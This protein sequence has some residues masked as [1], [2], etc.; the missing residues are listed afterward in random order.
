VL[1]H[2]ETLTVE[3]LP[4]G[5]WAFFAIAEQATGL[6]SLS[7]GTAH[8]L[9]LDARLRHP[10]RSLTLRAR[11]VQGDPLPEKIVSL[12]LHLREASDQD[13]ERLLARVR[14]VTHLS[15]RG[16]PVSDELIEAI[17]PRWRLEYLDVVDTR[18][19]DECVRRIRARYPKLRTHPNPDIG[20]TKL[21]DD[22]KPT[23]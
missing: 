7:L 20:L 12:H 14:E 4:R 18:V 10:L 17:V 11:S 2:L 1:R 3:N 5:A 6:D 16:T 9:V 23:E 8:D 22:A 19:G 15:V 21:E 13:M